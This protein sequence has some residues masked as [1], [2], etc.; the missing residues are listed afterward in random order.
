MHGRGRDKALAAVAFWAVAASVPLKN[1]N[2]KIYYAS[3]SY[4]VNI[5]CTIFPLYKY[6]LSSDRNVYSNHACSQYVLV[7]LQLLQG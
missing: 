6:I 2:M 1:K 3:Q 4:N 5:Y 7:K